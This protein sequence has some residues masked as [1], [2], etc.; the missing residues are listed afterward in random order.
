MHGKIVGKYIRNWY[1]LSLGWG[2]GEQ[3]RG[4]VGIYFH[5][6]TSVVF[7]YF[8]I[9]FLLFFFKVHLQNVLRLLI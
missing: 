7:E 9:I 1:Q 3:I 2:P 5:L 6:Y 4:E 8:V